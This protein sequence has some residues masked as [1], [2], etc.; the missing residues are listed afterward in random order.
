MTPPRR[1]RLVLLVLAVALAVLG[2]WRGE[3]VWRWATAERFYDDAAHWTLNVRGYETSGRWWDHRE[4]IRWYT[5]TGFKAHEALYR[6]TLCVRETYWNTDGTVDYQTYE[7][8]A[9]A[10]GQWVTHPT[11][12]SP[13]WLWG[14]TDQTE[15]TMPEWMKYDAKWQ[16]AI[17]AQE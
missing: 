8:D 9:K 2:L 16:A 11:Q 4:S 10:R 13:P 1:A 14:V 7:A 12:T 6:D 17:D 5:D 3:A 15:P